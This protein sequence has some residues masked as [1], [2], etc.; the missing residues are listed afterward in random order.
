MTRSGHNPQMLGIGDYQYQA[1]GGFSP[2]G[3][4]QR[5]GPSR[6]VI[7]IGVVAVAVIVYFFFIRGDAPPS[8][9]QQQAAAPAPA[10]GAPTG[11]E[12]KYELPPLTDSDDFMR[13]KMDALSS[14]PLMAAWLKGTDLVRNVVVVL[15][16]T[17][18]GLTP[19][20]HLRALRPSDQFRV[21]RQGVRVMIDPLSYER[22]N[23]LAAAAASI[24]PTAAAALY[25][26]IKPLL[27]IAYDE[28]GHEEKIDAALERALLEVLRA[29]VI[30]TNVRVERDDEGIG[31]RFEDPA[32]ETLSGVQKQMMRMGPTNERLI[33]SRVRQ[34]GIAA[35]LPPERLPQVATAPSP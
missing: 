10:A 35:G 30:P 13:E 20:K 24:D 18:G 25:T 11:V 26:T 31:Y 19:S 3:F 9:P 5:R 34:F 22:F 28:L 16:N 2:S 1:P 6:P 15:E 12:Q 29:P 27:Q 4:R 33:Q 17:A 14:D 23:G 7:I 32:L 8:S 21:M